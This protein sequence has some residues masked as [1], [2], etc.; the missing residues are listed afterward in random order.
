[1]IT[2]SPAVCP[3]CGYSHG[4]Y[5]Q[6]CANCHRCYRCAGKGRNKHHSPRIPRRC[7]CSHPC[8]PYGSL[9]WCLRF[10]A[11]NRDAR[12]LGRS[13]NA[14]VAKF[15]SIASPVKLVGGTPDAPTCIPL[16]TED[17]PLVP[18]GSAL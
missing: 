15:H 3:D 2:D 6:V 8:L 5:L 16:R 13:G 14:L 18:F 1:M 17:P 12:L 11:A 10:Q 7:Q 4:A 9:E